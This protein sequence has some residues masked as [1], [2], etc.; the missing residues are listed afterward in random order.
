VALDYFVEIENTGGSLTSEGL[1]HALQPAFSLQ[2]AE[3]LLLGQGVTVSVFLNDDEYHT[4]RFGGSRPD[5]CAAFRIKREPQLMEVGI[6]N[7]LSM[8]HWL[9]KKAQG[10][11]VLLTDEGDILLQKENGKF[12][13]HTGH[14][15]W[16]VTRA[17]H[18]KKLGA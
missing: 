7:M 17:A 4:S 9:M 6:H 3:K 12:K 8:A 5:I 13:P 14:S 16:T 15:F 10:D 2:K 18:L 11:A 1:A